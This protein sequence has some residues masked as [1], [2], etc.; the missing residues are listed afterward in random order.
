MGT[1]NSAATSWAV[2]NLRSQA[3]PGAA[4]AEPVVRAL[5]VAV[6]GPCCEQAAI[7]QQAQAAAA[8]SILECAMSCSESKL[9]EESGTSTKAF[10]RHS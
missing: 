10:R 1:V 8:K 3:L 2:I 9:S 5:L 4:V 7:V 6:P